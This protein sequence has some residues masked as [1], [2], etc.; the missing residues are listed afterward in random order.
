MGYRRFNDRRGDAW[1]V[2]DQSRSEWEFVPVSRESEKPVWVPAPG[3]EGDPFELSL[4]ELQR[5]L[6]AAQAEQAR[7]GKKKSPFGD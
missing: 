2:K 6:E 7:R 1:E 4:E 3:Y 5:M